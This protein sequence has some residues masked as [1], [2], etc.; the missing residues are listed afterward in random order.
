GKAGRP[1]VNPLAPPSPGKSPKNGPHLARDGIGRQAHAAP[2]APAPAPAR[3][4]VEA[5]CA[6]V[7][8]RHSWAISE[9]SCTAS[10]M[11]LGLGPLLSGWVAG[12]RT[13]ALARRGSSGAGLDYPG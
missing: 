6:T 8:S 12:A 9:R 7:T 11:M 10:R 1:W 3:Q 4:Q 13:Q 2:G 5:V